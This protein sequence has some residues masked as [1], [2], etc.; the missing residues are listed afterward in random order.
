MNDSTRQLLAK[1]EQATAATTTE[2]MDDE[3]AMLRESWLAF[4]QLVGTADT[5]SEPRV[6]VPRKS[7]SA[8]WT[9]KFIVALAASLL[10]AFAAWTILNRS[11]GYVELSPEIAETS[12][13]PA[14]ASITAE[15]TEAP[16]GSAPVDVV[17]K[18]AWEDSFD[19]QLASTSQAIR[20]VQADW[21][22][23]DRRYSLLLDQFEQ[24]SSELGEGSL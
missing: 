3:T 10:V 12:E 11:S 7:R 18:F 23:G 1:L 9:V 14:T 8:G 17:D 2:P 19:E 24:F 13:L 15:V 22:G 5:E 20:S 4:G 21:S 6:K 16:K